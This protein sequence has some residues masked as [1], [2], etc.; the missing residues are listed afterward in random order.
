MRVWGRHRKD[1]HTLWWPIIDEV[2][3]GLLGMSEEG[4]RGL[5]ERRIV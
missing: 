1:G 5:H 2:F 4:L 3:E